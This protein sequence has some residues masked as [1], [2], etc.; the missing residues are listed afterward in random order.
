MVYWCYEYYLI[1]IAE[2]YKILYR[3]S[4]MYTLSALACYL[5]ICMDSKKKQFFFINNLFTQFAD[6]PR[7]SFFRQLVD[8]TGCDRNPRLGLLGNVTKGRTFLLGI[9]LWYMQEVEKFWP[10]AEEKQIN[11]LKTYKL[12]MDL[13]LKILFCTWLITYLSC[14]LINV[15]WGYENLF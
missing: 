7:F 10:A 3:S 5:H 9:L 15:L 1:I 12:D 8:W 4:Y 6:K 13:W 14:R 2:K 11:K